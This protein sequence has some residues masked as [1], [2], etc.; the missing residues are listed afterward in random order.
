MGEK[1][2]KNGGTKWEK[3]TDFR[4]TKELVKA[5]VYAI[6]ASPSMLRKKKV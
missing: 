5:G 1:K 6:S 2:W 4:K 3:E